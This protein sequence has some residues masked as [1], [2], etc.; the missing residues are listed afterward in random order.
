MYVLFGNLYYFVYIIAAVILTIG[1][2]SFL[3]H[4]T[5]TFRHW[6]IFGLILFAF[7]VHFLKIF[8][9]P[10]TTNVEFIY[11]KISFENICAVSTLTFPFLYFTKNKTLKDYMIMVGI[12]SGIL[13]FMFPVD[14]ISEYFDGRIVGQKEAFSLEV[15][16]FYMA[17][18]L[19]FLSPFLMMTYKMH[20][21][22]IKRAWRAPLVL[23]GVLV[24]IYINELVLTAIGWVPRTELYDPQF[25]NP[26]FIFGIRGDLS[27]LGQIILVFVP[28][29]MYSYN[30]VTMSYDFWPVVWLV[31]PAIFYGGAMVLIQMFI[32]DKDNTILFFKKLFSRLPES[33]EVKESKHV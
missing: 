23:I 11:T 13:T 14:A 7:V 12:A 3:N 6:F 19:L 29:F 24:L 31:F 10:Y 21:L 9:P 15:I 22:S 28:F 4:R 32:F 16:R 2:V 26:S 8:I 27:G 33:T 5:Q 25:R 18:Y 20:T 30:S 17:H 1:L